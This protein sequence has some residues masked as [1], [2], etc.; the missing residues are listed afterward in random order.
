MANPWFKFKQFSVIQDKAAM[1]VGTDGVLLGAWAALEECKTIL[2]IGTGTGLIA[3]MAAQR[4]KKAHITAID[5]DEGAALQAKVNFENSGWSNRLTAI[6]TSLTEYADDT[7]QQFDSI[8][9]NPPY[10]KNAFKSDNNARNMARHAD[11]MPYKALL[12]HAFSL[13]HAEGLLAVVIPFETEQEFL[14]LSSVYGFFLKR[15][16]RIQSTPKKRFVRSLIELSKRKVGQVETDQMIIED[17]G[18]HAYSD[19]Y[20]LLTKDFYLGF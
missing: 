1:K 18:R 9:C 7:V 20:I 17:K 4:N 15:L 10:F 14:N 11:S 19:D 6:H 12:K 3:L 16:M 8:I 13:T 2:D 5:I